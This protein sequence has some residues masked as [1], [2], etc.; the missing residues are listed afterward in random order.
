MPTPTLAH[1]FIFIFFSCLVLSCQ[2]PYRILNEPAAI[3]ANNTLPIALG[4]GMMAGEASDASVILQARLTRFDTLDQ[5]YLP[6][7]N[8]WLK[9]LYQE[10]G[11]PIT[12]RSTAWLAAFPERDHIIKQ[13]IRALKSNQVYEYQALYGVDTIQYRRSE[14]HQFKTHPGAANT[15]A[16]RFAVVTGMNYYKF[17]FGNYDPEKRYKG[18]DRKLGYPALESMRRLAPDYFI[19]TGDNVYFDHP[20]PRGFERARQA[21]IE[22]A[23]GWF[24]GTW[25]TDEA[26]MRRKYHV[27]FVQPRFK[28]LFQ[29]T[30]TYW[31]KD[32]HDY[33]LNDADP[34]SDFPI[35]HEMGIKN[36]REQL[37]VTDPTDNNALTY[38]TFRVS[39][40]LQIWL[41]EGRDYRNANEMPDG[42][43]KSLWGATQKTWLQNTLLASDATFKILISPTPMVGPD[44][45][46]K[47]DN[48]VNQ[49]GFRHEGDAF[50]NWLE[51]NDF[52]EKNFYIVCGDRHWQY[53]AR[54]PSG[55][56]EFSTGALVDNN[57]R[58]G[59]L[60]GD[61]Q[62]TDPDGLIQQLYIQGTPES[63]SGGF[64]IF[65]TERKEDV[66]QAIFSFYNEQGQLL[67]EAVKSA[68]VE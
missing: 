67:Y 41:V 32:D 43:N 34:Y 4:Q 17:H 60:A 62:S 7:Q 6:G 9:F 18:E 51:E 49:K 50:F 40:D 45:A 28:Q 39:K 59:R 48:H 52:L 54:H 42:P 36:F 35:T 16:V 38:R 44:D 13:K 26:G 2:S 1:S 11:S 10:A 14:V 68:A 64:L 58:A 19:G 46:Y 63:A 56:E 5:G 47:K 21:G 8:G 66:P 31:E 3:N 57:A 30:A 37:P 55:F 27:Q 15:V 23:Q 29:Q 53:H 24:E 61:P 22:P 33:R 65:R 20:A 25:V 12:I